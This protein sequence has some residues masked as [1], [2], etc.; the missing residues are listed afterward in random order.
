MTRLAAFVAAAVTLC[1][2]L[3]VA[4]GPQVMTW[5][6]DGDTRQAIVYAPSAKSSS[7]RA[8]LVLSFHGRGDNMR[9]FQMTDM[10]LAWPE[11]IVAYFQGLPGNRDG[12][13]GWQVE[14]GQD[15]DRDLKLV[16]TA[17][18]ALRQR[19]SVDVARIYSTG[20]SNGAIF[21]YLLW[22]ER[23]DVFA[24]FA[25]VAGRLRPSMTLK[26]P[27]PVIHTAGSADR[28]IAFSAQSEAIDMTKR[29]D[30][31]SDEGT[32]CGAGCTIYAARSATPVVTWIHPGGHEYPEGTSERI[33]D[34]FR[35]HTRR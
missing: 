27:K 13:S 22:A 25:P 28:T 3:V 18:A 7:G 35:N 26:Q 20:F 5:N 12:V 6:V 19:F 23:S 31:V 29:V 14:R 10:H 15:H 9:N 11:A 21:T 32:G 30:G 16:D 1:G 33:V 24:A 2:Q 17:L 4:E 34:F 8:P